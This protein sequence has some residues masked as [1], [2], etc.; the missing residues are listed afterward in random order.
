MSEFPNQETLFNAA[1]QLTSAEARAAFLNA[2]CAGDSGLRARLDQLLDAYDHPA[3]A[4][5]PPIAATILAP[6]DQPE[7]LYITSFSARSSPFPTGTITDRQ[8]GAVCTCV[9]NGFNWE[10]CDTTLSTTNI[11]PGASTSWIIVHQSK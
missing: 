1:V 4:L 5:E 6:R 7:S 2:A 10:A 9:M 3:S 8:P 11:P